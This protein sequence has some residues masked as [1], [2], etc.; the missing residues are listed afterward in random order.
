MNMLMNRC[1]AICNKAKG[2]DQNHNA[3]D[4]IMNNCT[5]MTLKSISEKSY[6]Y[7]I[8]EA[9][10]EGHEVRL[11]NCIAIN[12]NEAT[13]T[14]DK[15]TGQPK[16]GE[17]GK[18]GLY[19]RFEVDETLDR[20]TVSHCEFQKADPTQFVDV[21]NHHE[22]IAPRGDDGELPATTFAH[23]TSSSFLVDAGVP[24]EETVYRGVQLECDGYLGA[25]PDLGAYEY[26]N[27]DPTMIG[28]LS[29]RQ[30]AGNGIRLRQ[31]AGGQVLVMVDA[32]PD[33]KVLCLSVHD[34]AGRLLCTRDFSGCTTLVTL[35]KVTG[36]VV[37]TVK[38]Q[39][40]KGSMKAFVR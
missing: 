11:T 2:F 40:F 37:L 16:P 15:T 33:T 14:R 23:P 20:L 17:H 7:R 25:A 3:G 6:S 5:G 26:E 34:T 30:V 22:L 12:D 24:L 9:I 1:L 35:P 38:G 39:D 8:Y 31:L 28:R 32:A 18:Y 27:D 4:I 13:D 21:E 10:A 29:E 36:P 19:G